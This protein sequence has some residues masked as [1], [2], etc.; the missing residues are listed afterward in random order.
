MDRCHKYKN[1]LENWKTL[2]SERKEVRQRHKK[3]QKDMEKGRGSI[4]AKLFA[5]DEELLAKP[6]P[7]KPKPAVMRQVGIADQIAIRSYVLGKTA[8]TSKNLLVLEYF[9]IFH[10]DIICR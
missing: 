5:D 3:H 1:N 9:S 7:E 2:H 4:D 6:E 10:D 8:K